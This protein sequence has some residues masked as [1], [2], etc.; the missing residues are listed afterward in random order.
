MG[1]VLGLIPCRGG[2]K[3][4]RRKNVQPVAGKPLLAHTVGAS[5]AAGNVDRTLVSTDDREIREAAR[6]AGAD[7]PFLRPAELATDEAPIEPVVAHA[8]TYLREEESDR[9]DTV[10]LLQATSP[11]R[12]ATHVDEALDRY[13]EEGADSLVAVYESDSYRWRRTPR[14]AEIVNYETRKRRQDK[15]PE[16]VESGAI[17]LVDADRFLDSEELQAGRTALYVIDRVSAL[18]IDEPFELWLADRILREWR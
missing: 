11:L 10:A 14:G 13:R 17:Y 7:A 5:L 18:D 16:Y 12:T 2:S 3:G 1:R 8:L 9:Y 4:I 6:G 15:D